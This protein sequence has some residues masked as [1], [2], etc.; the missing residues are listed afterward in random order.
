MKIRNNL[1]R[2]LFCVNLFLFVYAILSPWA[3]KTRPSIIEFHRGGEEIY[4]SFQ[5][6]F[7]PYRHGYQNRLLSW[8]FW[9]GHHERL[10][11]WDFWF[12]RDMYLYGFTFGWIRL[13]VFQLLTVFSGIYVLI[14][15]WQRINY[16]LIPFF[17]SVLSVLIG[18]ELVSRYMFVWRGYARPY[19]GLPIAVFLTLGFLGILISKYMLEKRGKK[20][21]SSNKKGSNAPISNFLSANL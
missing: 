21:Q 12:A 3:G 5:V 7:Y 14:W 10:L 20:I 1:L 9:F 15:R 19:W 16:L 17:F 4:W 6:V 13:F 2:V 8:D 11:L 18:L